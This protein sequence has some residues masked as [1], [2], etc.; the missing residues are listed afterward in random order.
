MKD[1]AFH[2]YVALYG[3]GVVNDNLLPLLGSDE[4]TPVGVETRDVPSR[5]SRRRPIHGPALRA[6]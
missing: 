2:A 1:A 3:K 6:D 4:E 5:R